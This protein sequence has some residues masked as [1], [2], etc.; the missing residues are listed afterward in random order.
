M[1]VVPTLPIAVAVAA[2]ALSAFAGAGCDPVPEGGPAPETPVAQ[3]FQAAPVEEASPAPTDAN[4]SP[5]FVPPAPPGAPAP[6]CPTPV[7]VRPVVAEVKVPDGWVVLPGAPDPEAL[8]CANL[9]R[10]EWAVRRDAN[11]VA[12]GLA[13]RRP[14]DD[15]LPFPLTGKAKEGLAGRR[16]VKPIEGGFLVGFD[17]GEFGG[18]LWW[19][20]GAGDR[21]QRIVDENVVGFVDLGGAPVAITGLAH[22]GMSRGRALRLG[23]DGYGGYRV[24]A[25]VDLGGAAQA[26]VSEG[27]D[28]VLIQTTSGLMRLTACGDLSVLGNARYDV[29]YPTSMAV[30]D[31]GVVSIGMRHFVARWIPSAGGYREEWLTRI[32]CARTRVKKFECVCGG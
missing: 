1:R 19:F 4:A 27:K 12:I 29:L 6:T 7:P 20:G 15:A 25:W 3:V 2:L 5:P 8:R 31:A 9:S 10:K 28:T 11:D 13:P 17:A 14:V 16:R 24:V 32:D 22:L 23:P 21:R 30:D 26:F 18:A